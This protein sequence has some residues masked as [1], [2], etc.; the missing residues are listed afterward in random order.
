MDVHDPSA[1]Y[2]AARTAAAV[3]D[4]GARGKLV[5][6]G[7]DRRSYLHA[8]LTCDV[9][10]LQAGDGCYGAL[11]TPQG[12]MIADM[13]LLE[14]GDLILMDLDRGRAA[15]VAQKLDQFIFSEDVRLGD[16]SETF[17]L[18]SVVGPSSA[19]VVSRVL[20]GSDAGSGVDAGDLAAWPEFR[21]ARIEWAG[22][23]AILAASAELG[24]PGFD[25]FSPAEAAGALIAALRR[26][27]GAPL[28][29]PTAEVL[30]VE[31]GRPAFGLDMDSE[32]IPLEAGIEDRAISFTKG[33]YPGQE[34]VIRILHR[35]HGRVARKL[36]GLLIEGGDPVARGDL[37]RSGERDAGRVTSP[38]VS[39]RLGRP[40][41][42]AMVQRDFLEPGTRL[43][44]LHDAALIDATVTALPFVEA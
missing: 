5:V 8:M 41:A 15:D 32:T 42:L 31:A 6:A 11:L 27:G 36:A 1:A 10:A 21:N 30:R 2:E 3:L 38:V 44:V 16:V 29:E 34:I 12:R 20:A 7:S 26:E 43:T 17:G 19:E 4:R 35:G 33:C 40:I 14:L 25:L 22:Q 28:D 39:R 23:P 9:A 24:V 37:L 18:A 13:R